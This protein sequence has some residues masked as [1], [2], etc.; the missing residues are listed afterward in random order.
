[1]HTIPADGWRAVYVKEIEG[2]EPTLETRPLICFSVI[3]DM[4]TGEEQMVG[5]IAEGVEIVPCLSP[6]FLGY[7]P[8]D[9]RPECMLEELQ[10]WIKEQAEEAEREKLAAEIREEQAK[11]PVQHGSN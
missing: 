8:R 11:P 3:D 9:H 2:Y 7:L 10:A 1:M 6:T 4:D 5:M